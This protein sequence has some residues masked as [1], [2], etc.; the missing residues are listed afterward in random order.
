MTTLLGYRQ[1]RLGGGGPKH[2]QVPAGT[3]Q[4]FAVAG[5]NPLHLNLICV[6]T[7]RSTA[8]ELDPSSGAG[9]AAVDLAAPA[10][11][12]PVATRPGGKQDPT[13]WYR[14]ASGTSFAAAEVSGAA[15]LLREAAPG[16][17]MNIIAKA[18]RLGAR[19]QVGMLTQVRFGQLDVACAALWLVQHSQP[20]WH[21]RVTAAGLGASTGHC[22][23]Q[24]IATYTD[25]WTFA[26][27]LFD[28]NG[29][30]SVSRK[31]RRF[32]SGKKLASSVNGSRKFEAISEQNSRLLP[33]GVKW[34]PKT[35][36]FFPIEPGGFRHPVAPPQRVIYD[37][38]NE[39]DEG[40]SVVCPTGAQLIDFTL[41]MKSFLPAGYVFAAADFAPG[42][43]HLFL[44]VAM[45]KPPS[46]LDGFVPD[47]IRVFVV[48]RCEFTLPG[49]G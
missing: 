44:N 36:A 16:A 13:T 27:S 4:R 14:R 24:P 46:L 18:L 41:R 30:M 43:G 6:A 34:D 35:L 47:P 39:I 48:V 49:G 12:I 33:E 3:L 45:L 32:E 22:F 10:T 15:G 8:P 40:R 1:V 5:V 23:K 42:P 28:P 31:L 21:L 19:R 38:N 7:S 17:P 20:E 2:E 9:N 26:K 11:N 37:F 29:R 25:E